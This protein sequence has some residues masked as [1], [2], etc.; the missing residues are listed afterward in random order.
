MKLVCSQSSLSA[1]LNLVSRAVSS[2]PSHPVLANVLFIAD[3]DTQQIKLSAFDLSLGIQTSFPADVI[4]GGKLTLPAKLL[5]DIVSRLP[6]GDITLEDGNDG[7][8]EDSSFVTTLTCAT[9]RYQ[10]RGM[11]AEEFPEL[12]VVEGGDVAHLPVES[13]IE[14][15]KSSLFSASSDETKQVLTGVHLTMQSDGLE[16]AATDGHRLTVVQTVDVEADGKD[17]KGKGAKTASDND[18]DVTIPAKALQELTKLLER[19]TGSDVAVHFDQSQVVFEWTDQRLTS[20]LLEGQYPNYR[21]LVP[22]QFSR[23]VTAERRL[24]LSALERIA[25]LADQ[26]NNIVKL[27][28]DS[29]S[30]L[31][32]LSVDAQDVG[33]GKE[34]I[35]AQITGDDLDVAFNVKYLMDGLKAIATTEI[36]IQ[37]NTATSPAIVTPLGS[38]KMTYLVMPVQVRS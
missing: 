18:L 35:P 21:Q 28:L 9:G 25:V 13:L 14:G 38:I 29:T 1:N 16:F 19:Q 32:S 8:T 34:T 10:V 5:T 12:P 20:R 23:Q 24:L 7:A 33:S 22:R 2:R 27:T 31:L 3:E 37:L 26:K 17:A 11:G 36:Q 4:V 15:L 30:Q 6:E